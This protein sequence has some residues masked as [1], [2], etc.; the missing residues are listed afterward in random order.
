VSHLNE[1]R[2]RPSTNASKLEM[3]VK[4]HKRE[5]IP[6]KY[7]RCHTLSLVQKVKDG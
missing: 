1:K 6:S 3:G 7:G 2:A 4:E 5:Q